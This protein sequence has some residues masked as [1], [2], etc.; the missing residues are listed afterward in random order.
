MLAF[1]APRRYHNIV[2]ASII[3]KSLQL[4]KLPNQG[5]GRVYALGNLALIIEK[6]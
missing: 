5:N 1:E 4:A 3:N 2:L 6:V